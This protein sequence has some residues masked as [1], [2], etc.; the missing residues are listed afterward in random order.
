M[1][2]SESVT[3]WPGAADVVETPDQSLTDQVVLRLRRMLEAGELGEPL[4]PER[5]LAQL[6]GVSRITLRRAMAR[7]E[8]D[9]FVT[10]VQG[11]GTFACDG[12]TLTDI[13]SLVSST[14]RIVAVLVRQHGPRFNPQL[15]PWTWRICRALTPYLDRAGADLCLVNDAEFMNA[16]ARGRLA[17]DRLLGFVAPTHQW[18]TREYEAA[19][20]CNRP[21]VGLGRT[22]QSMFWNIIDL[23]W[24]NA[25][26]Q[27]IEDLRPAAKDRVFIPMVPHPLEVDQQRWLETALQSLHRYGIGC[28]QIVVSADGPYESQ[29][30]LA[31][32]SYLRQYGEPTIVL[33]PFDLSIVGAYRALQAHGARRLSRIRFLGA[34]NLEIGQYLELALSTLGLDY[35]RMAQHIMDSFRQ[36]RRT[37]L[38]QP[39][40]YEPAEYIRRAS[41][42]V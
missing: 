41:S 19:M 21:W 40:R 24:V 5:Q 11:R 10:R 26:Q 17:D 14:R 4:P 18:S 38:A 28:G 29:G 3:A 37:G 33:S 31:M 36:S 35:D 7:L 6:F 8:A 12:P 22:S 34:A 16:M 23:D 13:A 39:L 20:S 1:V 9:G 25:L 30:Y 27:A 15:T 32:R 2:R 42:E